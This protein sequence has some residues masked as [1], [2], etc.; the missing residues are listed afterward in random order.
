MFVHIIPSFIIIALGFLLSYIKIA[1]ASWVDML[2]TFG[3]YVGFPILIFANLI[4][5]STPQLLEQLPTL[6]T[7]MGIIVLFMLIMILI[8]KLFHISK[9]IAVVMFLASYNGNIGYLGFPLITGVLPNSRPTIGLI[10]SAYS[11]ITFTIGILLLE[12]ITGEEK[13]FGKIFRNILTTPFF[14]STIAGLAV[15]LFSIPIPEFFTGALDMMEPAVAPLLLLGLGVFINKK[16]HLRTVLRPTLIIFCIKMFIFPAL[17]IL[18]SR[19]FD[20]AHYFDTA[21][22]EAAMPVGLTNFALSQRYAMN[23]DVMLSLIM[24][25]TILTPF[26]F[27]VIVS[28]L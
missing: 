18:T 5:I 16:I 4:D 9:E 28:L 22:L 15:I 27:P 24:L 20:F 7:T 6:F 11:V 25:T 10:I 3:L 26:I 12:T 2:N 1:D 8:I 14:L 23:K 17:F 21:V 13:T 19:I